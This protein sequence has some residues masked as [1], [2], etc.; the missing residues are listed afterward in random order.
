MNDQQRDC[1]RVFKSSTY[2]QF[3]NNNPERV[4]GTCLW[5]LEHPQYI[6]WLDSKKDDLLWI[7][8]DPGCGKSVLSRSLIENELC[9][10]PSTVCYFF[11]KDN[12]Q[13]DRLTIALCA[14]LHQLLGVQPQLLKHA[15][16][17]WQKNGEKLREETGRLWDILINAATDQDAYDIICVLD[18]LDECRENDRRALLG[19]LSKFY[20]QSLTKHPRGRS[21][22]FLVTSRPYHDIESGFREI[23]P[24]LPNIR[25]SGEKEDEKIHQEI[26]LVIRGE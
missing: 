11:F 13:Q 12:E 15:I 7:S 10:T 20:N 23:P 18:A 1:H 16:P 3:K 17:E 8:A 14:L 22:K 24:Y 26:D 25:L 9:S 19:L 6:Q 5:V 4:S 21:L 2:E